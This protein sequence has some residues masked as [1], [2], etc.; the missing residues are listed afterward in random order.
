MNCVCTLIIIFIATSIASVSSDKPTCPAGN[1]P[2]ISEE[3]N[4]WIKFGNK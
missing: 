4:E 3:L 1:A 2:L